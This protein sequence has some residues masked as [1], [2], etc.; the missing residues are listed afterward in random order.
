MTKKRA[1]ALAGGGPAAGLHIGALQALKDAGITFD[2][3]ALSCIGA[4]VGIVYNQCDE[5]KEV[6]QTREFFH[7]HVFRDDASY[8]RFPINSVFGLDWLGN[9][10]AFEKFIL[11]PANYKNIWLPGAMTDATQEINAFLFDRKKWSQGDFNDLILELSAKNPFIRF[12]MS[13]MYLSEINGMTRIHYPKGSLLKSIDFEKLRKSE[14]FIY[15]NAWNL[16]RKRLEQ[17][18]NRPEAIEGSK[19]GKY[20]QLTA[21][22]L[23]AC[24]ALPYIEQTVEMG[25]DTYCE[26]ALVD[27]VNLKRLLDDHP[28]LDEIWISR[29]IDDEQVRPPR[30]LHDALGNLCQL[31]A[32]TVGEDDIELFRYRAK[33]RG[34]SDDEIADKIIEIEVSSDINFDW[35]RSNL[36]RG[37]ECGRK[38]V[39]KK[40]AEL[41]EKTET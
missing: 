30:N 32:A 39:E 5:G 35:T 16:S 13:M 10:K 12:Y 11:D 15:H 36:K 23:C 34:W 18:A 17:F 24:S 1:I 9:L 21:Q 22:S 26:G 6:Q 4:W 41:A 27:T 25:G 29:I 38:A 20:G 2:V 14:K 40:L 31:F 28:D 8:S 19:L 37:I 7:D 33:D 3:W